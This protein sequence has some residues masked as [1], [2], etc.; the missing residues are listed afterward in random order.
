MRKMTSRFHL[1]L[2]LSV[3]ALT[4][5]AGTFKPVPQFQAQPI[6]AGQYAKR[7]EHLIFIMDA[8]SSMGD[9][10][11]EY[12]KLDTA[13]S[14][15]SNFNNT[16]PNMDLAVAL[17][18]FGHDPGVSSKQAETM[19]PNQ[20]YSR[21]ALAAALN[22]VS[23][24]GGTSPLASA[25]GRAGDEI[26][27]AKGPIAMVVVSDGKD[28][29]TAPLAAAK[30]L[31]TA[32]GD[33]LCIYTVLVGDA[34]DGRSL[35]KNLAAVSDCGG[36]ISADGLGNAAAMNRFVRQVLFTKKMDSDG[37]GVADD[38][39]RCPDTATGVKVDGN[40]CAMDSDNDGVPDSMDQCPQTPA[41]TKV[42]AKGCATPMA[43][44]SA[45]VTAAGTWI[46]RGQVH[47]IP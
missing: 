46:Y 13:K 40:G 31:K 45:E 20:R 42:D 19:L 5:C 15:I 7:A 12:R 39:D 44:K 30:A 26:K 16:M 1:L 8:S 6:E 22:K 9:S 2:T 14:V 24:P 11:Q 28:M 37:D 38:M 21:S 36:A 35:L 32:L 47:I 43:T 18:T 34:A 3:F 41:G 10:H 4:A 23:A 17:H 25:I 29:G 27:T 33:R